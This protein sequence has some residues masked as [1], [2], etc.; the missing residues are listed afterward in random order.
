MPG[1]GGW[2]CRLTHPVMPTQV[3]IHA[4][5]GG[6]GRKAWMPILIGMTR[7]SS[8]E[9]EAAGRFSS[10]RAQ[11]RHPRLVTPLATILGDASM[12]ACPL[13]DVTFNLSLLWSGGIASWP[14]KKWNRG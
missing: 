13:F 12:L 9:S 5:T 7:V 10:L 6:I 8:D 11:A 2:P 4:F 1:G 3:G 14:G